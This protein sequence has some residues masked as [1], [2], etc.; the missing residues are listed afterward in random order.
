M[1]LTIPSYSALKSMSIGC[2]NN[3]DTEAK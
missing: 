1:P 3:G 2:E